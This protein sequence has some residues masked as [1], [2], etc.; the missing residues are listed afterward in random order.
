M[1]V[2]TLFPIIALGIV[3]FGIKEE[4]EVEVEELQNI[5]RLRTYAWDKKSGS[6]PAAAAVL[7]PVAFY[8]LLLVV[9]EFHLYRCYHRHITNAMYAVVFFM[10]SWTAGFFLHIFVQQIS[11]IVVA[12][13][14]P[15]YWKRCAPELNA[16]E[17]LSCGKDVSDG[18]ASFFS[19]H[20]SSSMMTAAY[21]T[22]YLIWSVYFRTTGIK[23]PAAR[24]FRNLK[25]NS[26]SWD[27]FVHEMCHGAV[28]YLVLLQL[29]FAWIVGVSRLL[30]NR[31]HVW[32]VN[33]GFIVG[34]IV[35]GVFGVQAAGLYKLM[36]RFKPDETQGSNGQQPGTSETSAC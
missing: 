27:R 1:L 13:P 29:G 4:P 30:D 16:L 19:G 32:D 21:S 28:M 24:L 6:I 18:L 14:R 25:S 15:D 3:L 5:L 36:P 17:I 11:V 35:G 33:S 12:E 31:H 26:S 2:L 8:L 9:M 7:V 23:R 34:A 10:F 22:V 20:A